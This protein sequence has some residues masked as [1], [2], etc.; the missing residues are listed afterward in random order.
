MRL[1]PYRPK[2]SVRSRPAVLDAVVALALAGLSAYVAWPTVFPATAKLGNIYGW[3]PSTMHL[4]GVGWIAAIGV[5]LAVLPLRRK[6]PVTVLAVTL[7]AAVA[8]WMLLPITISPADV[9]VAIAV[10]TVADARPRRVSAAVVLSGGLLAVGLDTLLAS[11]SGVQQRKLAAAWLV[12]PSD[13]IVPA[14]ALAAAWIAGDGA[15]TRRAYTAAVERRAL[16]AERDRDQQAGLAAAAE[17]ERITRELHDVIAHALSVMVIQAQGAGSA[18]RRRQDG[19]AGDALDAIVTTGRGALAET[20]RVLGVIRRPDGAEPD[21]APQPALRDLPALAARVRRAGTPVRLDVTGDVRPLPEVIELSAY[22]IVQEA[23]T[24]TMKHAGPGAT[25]EVRVRYGTGEL[26]LDISD[27]KSFKSSISER[28]WFL[29][30]GNLLLTE[31]DGHE[32]A[33]H[34]LA[35]MRARV[36]MLGGEL[37]AGPLPGGGFRISARLPTPAPAQGLGGVVFTPQKTQP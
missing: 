19:Q 12:K 26:L 24:N 23:L 8:G 22:R 4:H 13:L 10:Y 11:A 35:G 28:H 37:S 7:A 14:V 17:R 16:D 36:A 6:L 25:A 21:L 34:G 30:P 9:A 29:P 2:A 33:G 20:R 27:I 5:E 31:Q 3:S 1:L 32:L 18:L 15:R